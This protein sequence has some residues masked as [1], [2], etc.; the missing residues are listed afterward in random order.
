MSR[1]QLRHCR[2]YGLTIV[3]A[4]GKLIATKIR[5]ADD[6]VLHDVEHSD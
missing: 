3:N 2:F 1:L 4:D 6:E 5:V